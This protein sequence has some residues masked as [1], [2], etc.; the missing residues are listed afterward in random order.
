PPS[1]ITL[2]HFLLSYLYFFFLLIRRPPSST[3]FPY[4]TLFRSTALLPGNRVHGPGGHV[5]MRISDGAGGGV[6]FTNLLAAAAGS[7]RAACAGGRDGSAVF[8]HR[9]GYGRSAPGRHGGSAGRR[10]SRTGAAQKRRQSAQPIAA[11]RQP[12]RR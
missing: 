3:L 1:C 5:C 10:V 11:R 2:A 6:V 12:A 8:E 7:D 4:T 9:R